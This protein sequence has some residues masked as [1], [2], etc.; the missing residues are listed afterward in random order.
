MQRVDPV[1][2][3][4]IGR[5][6]PIWVWLPRYDRSGSAATCSPASP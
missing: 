2:T 1:A 3:G 4:R 6:A 5:L